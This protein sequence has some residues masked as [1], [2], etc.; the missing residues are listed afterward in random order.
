MARRFS[1]ADL[2]DTIPV[3]PLPGALV[4]PRGRL[5]LNIFEP[6][7]LAMVDDA[8][9]TEHRLIGMVQPYE[10]NAEPPRLHSIGCAG[11]ITSLSETEDGRYLIVL[12]GIARFRVLDE[13]EGFTPY[14]RINPG[15]ADFAADL[16]G[17]ENI[18]GWDRGTFMGLL[19]KYFDIAN[20]SSDWDSMREADTEMLLNSLAMMCPFALEEKQALLEAPRLSD[21]AETL[22]ALLRF[23][24]AEGG[25][26]GGLQ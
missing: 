1:P 23:A 7:Y 4:L 8:L 5:P 24:I 13:P 16:K 3:F 18:D 21:R 19:K 9:K 15:W 6:R 12:T 14:R 26:S 25:K 2:P 10:G 20:L 17:P 11:R 22:T